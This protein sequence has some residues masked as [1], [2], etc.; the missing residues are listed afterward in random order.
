MPVHGLVQDS[1]VIH[2]GAKVARRARRNAKRERVDFFTPEF[3]ARFS[4]WLD[5]L[6]EKSK[7]MYAEA[8]EKRR[9]R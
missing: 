8:K 4:S 5:E 1:P 7:V 6:D 9:S 3:K 2:V